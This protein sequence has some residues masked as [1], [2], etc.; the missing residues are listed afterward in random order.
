MNESRLPVGEVQ[1]KRK[2][3]DRPFPPLGAAP[4]GYNRFDPSDVVGWR[5]ALDTYGFVVLAGVLSANEVATATSLLWDYL[6]HRIEGDR[7]DPGTWAGWPSESYRYG[8]IQHD[9]THCDGV[10]YLRGLPGVRAA[11]ANLFGTPDLHVSY[12]GFPAV[13][14]APAVGPTKRDWYHIDH[15]FDRPGRWLAQGLIAL[16]PSGADDGGLVVWPCSH[17][18]FAD[19]WGTPPRERTSVAILNDFE[20][21]QSYPGAELP[22]DIAGLGPVKVSMEAG[23]LAL[24]DSRTVHCNAPPGPIPNRAQHVPALADL[25]ASV[26]ARVPESETWSALPLCAEPISTGCACALCQGRIAIRPSAPLARLGAYVCCQPATQT[27]A[28]AREREAMLRAR[29]W[30]GHAPFRVV[31]PQEASAEPLPSAVAKCGIRRALAG[32]PGGATADGG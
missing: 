3:V 17:H 21:V 32:L 28:D 27:A 20:V 25:L 24:W 9:G 1:P 15:S 29:A 14:P 26:P 10:W 31:G 8:M 30:T 23:D 12:D 2:P 11:F 7:A 22:R 16:T 5:A 18:R 13:R 19:R 4:L 6:E